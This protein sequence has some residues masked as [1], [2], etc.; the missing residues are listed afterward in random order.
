MNWQ[1]VTQCRRPTF[2]ATDPNGRRFYIEQ[3]VRSEHASG[4]VGSEYQLSIS[5]IRQGEIR[6]E[7]P[8]EVACAFRWAEGYLTTP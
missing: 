6:L 8:G 3:T 7:A 1:R 4:M 5:G 2:Y